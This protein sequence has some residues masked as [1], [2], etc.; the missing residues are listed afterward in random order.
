MPGLFDHVLTITSNLGCVKIDTLTVDVVPSYSP[1]I[2]LSASDT[3]ILCGDSIFM[4][5]DL[6][7]GIPAV[8]GPSGSTACSASATY[9]T[10]GSNMVASTGEHS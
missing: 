3:N 7:G 2:T 6:G 4:T 10:V 8:C 9:Q 1:D 5:V